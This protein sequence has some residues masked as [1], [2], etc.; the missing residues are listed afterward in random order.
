MAKYWQIIKMFG[1]TG[2]PWKTTFHLMPI[3]PVRRQI[4]D[5]HLGAGHSVE[6]LNAEWHC[7]A[8]K[9]FTLT[10]QAIIYESIRHCKI[11]LTVIV[12]GFN[13]QSYAPKIS[14]AQLCDI[15]TIELSEPRTTT[16]C[17]PRS[18]RWIVFHL[19]IETGN[20][21][22]N[23]KNTELRNID[24]NGRN[25]NDN[26][27]NNNNSN[28]DTNNS[29]NNDTNNDDT[30]NIN[31][32]DE[33]NNDN[34]LTTTT[35]TTTTPKPLRWADKIFS[36]KMPFSRNSFS[37]KSFNLARIGPT[38]SCCPIKK[39]LKWIRGK[40]VFYDFDVLDRVALQRKNSPK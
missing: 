24:S 36:V 19:D 11:S 12:R 29:N 35:T 4:V 40:K 18:Y 37:R 21:R 5:G 33:E 13:L 15:S 1:H 32:S 27:G 8:L 14:F 39:W 20:A 16:T 34:N 28:R 7:F 26:I 17:Q 10:G 23:F 38:D 30:N 31:N 2:S 22:R 6:W 25:N 9:L 3:L